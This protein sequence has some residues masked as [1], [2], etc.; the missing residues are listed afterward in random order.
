M[1]LAFASVILVAFQVSVLSPLR[2]LGVVV[3]IVWLWPI[4][5]ALTGATTMAVGAGFV[6]G[7]LFDAQSHTPFGLNAFVAVG[8]ALLIAIP[9]REGVGDLDASAWWMPPA[10]L[11]LGGMVAPVL[12]VTLGAMSGHTSLWRSSMVA[13]MFVNC[14]GFFVL[15]RP[16]ARLA[17]RVANV[18]GWAR[19]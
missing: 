9:A 1:A 18:G 4:A 8:L 15:A 11:G 6:T 10:L 19:G 7:L 13:T 14:V 5:L 16:M 3:M 2:V 12:F 17:Q